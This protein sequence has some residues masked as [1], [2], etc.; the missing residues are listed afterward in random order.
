MQKMI[1]IST[2]IY[3]H[4]RRVHEYENPSEYEYG[5]YERFLNEYEYEYDY[6]LI[7]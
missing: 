2:I 4:S 5:E 1:H 6:R 7:F 3:L